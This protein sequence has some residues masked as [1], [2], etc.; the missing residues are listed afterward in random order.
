[1]KQCR[2]G[3]GG[4]WIR[5]RTRSQRHIDTVIGTSVVDKVPRQSV[6][7]HTG[8]NGGPCRNIPTRQVFVQLG[9]FDKTDKYEHRLF[10]LYISN[11]QRVFICSNQC[12]FYAFLK[13]RHRTSIIYMEW[14]RS[15]W[16]RHAYESTG[17]LSNWLKLDQ[18]VKRSL[19][20]SKRVHEELGKVAFL[21]HIERLQD[22]RGS[23]SLA[24]FVPS[25]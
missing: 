25:R 14:K 3:G 24:R 5:T 7:V 4:F 12:Y 16:R 21:A 17:R 8:H 13:L 11:S 15:S 22:G 6:S 1:M 20:V 10:V 18:I 19:R 9:H 23:R 2:G